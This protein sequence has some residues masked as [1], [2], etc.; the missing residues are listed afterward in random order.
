MGSINYDELP[1]LKNNPKYIF[2]VSEA[3]ASAA[4]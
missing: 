4:K 2:F 3:C 1:A